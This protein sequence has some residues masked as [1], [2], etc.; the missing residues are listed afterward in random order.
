MRRTGTSCEHIPNNHQF[1]AKRRARSVHSGDMMGRPRAL[2]PGDRV[3]CRMK[4][5]AGGGTARRRR[6]G[7]SRSAL[8]NSTH[9][10]S[11]NGAMEGGRRTAQRRRI[12]CV[13]RRAAAVA[14]A[15]ADVDAAAATAAKK[16][17]GTGTEETRVSARRRVYIFIHA[18]YK[19]A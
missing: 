12:S 13:A 15:A 7:R 1:S 16:L 3:L 17:S 4:G 10:S 6:S 5:G 11:A 18:V 8:K 14:A 2:P 19:R 9:R